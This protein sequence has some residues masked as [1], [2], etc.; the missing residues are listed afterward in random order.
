MVLKAGT[1]HFNLR[2]GRTESGIPVYSIEDYD[3]GMSVTANAAAV[4]SEVVAVTGPIPGNSIF[5]YRDTDGRW[6]GLNVVSG[7]FIDF[8]PLG[9]ITEDE[10]LSMA[11]ARSHKSVS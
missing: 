1:T 2:M 9:A 4:I 5:V 10:A 3:V 6:D 11:V 7:V 8:F